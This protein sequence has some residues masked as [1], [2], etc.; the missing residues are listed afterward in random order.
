MAEPALASAKG[1]R[2]W[3]FA[4]AVTG[5]MSTLVIYG[6]LQAS[7]LLDLLLVVMLV[8]NLLLFVKIGGV[9]L[10]RPEFSDEITK[11]S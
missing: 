9:G 10:S 4:F 5:I 8:R 1:S 2:A 7:S 3:R 11:I 6:I